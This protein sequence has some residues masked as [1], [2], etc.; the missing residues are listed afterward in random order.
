M[1]DFE[2]DDLRDDIDDDLKDDIDDEEVSLKE[3]DDG[4]VDVPMSPR[5]QKRGNRYAKMQAELEAG[6]R[7]RDEMRA[8]QRDFELAAAE[9]AGA[10]RRQQAPQKTV[11]ESLEEERERLATQWAGLSAEQRS[12]E[13]TQ[14]EY[15]RLASENEDRRI[16][17]AAERVVSRRAGN[18]QVET[19]RAMMAAEYPDVVGNAQAVKWSEGYWQMEA[20]K[21]RTGDMNLTREAFQAAREEFRTGGRRGTNDRPTAAEK[22]RFAGERKGA[23]G[24]AGKSS[25]TM[26]MS[27]DS[28]ALADELYPDL[29]ESVRYRKFAKE[30]LADSK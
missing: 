23:G 6:K 2:E 28:M 11:K 22:G 1:A 10:L 9:E 16:E 24:G 13:R 14:K 25:G 18:Q 17:H 19:N 5:R 30:V 8:Q 3:N 20:A 27:K 15:K 7:E 4:T 29:P 26:R 12:D 21:G